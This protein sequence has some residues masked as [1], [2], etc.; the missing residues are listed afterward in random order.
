MLHC[1]VCSYQRYNNLGLDELRTQLGQ[2]FDRYRI[3]S[4][5]QSG[6]STSQP[7]FHSFQSAIPLDSIMI[8]YDFLT[9]RHQNDLFHRIW[10]RTSITASKV[11]SELTIQD[12]VTKIWEPAFEE[13]CRILESLKGRTMKLREIDDR[14]KRYDGPGKIRGHLENLY[15]GVELCF[16]R[17]QS[18]AACPGWIK[19]AVESM[20]QY[21]TLSRYAK[22]AQTILELRRRL[23]L[24]G[25]FSIME[26]I[27][28]QVRKIRFTCMIILIILIQWM[29]S[30]NRFTCN[31]LPLIRRCLQP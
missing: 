14:F 24:T 2:N 26:T 27:A 22:A 23:E 15:K 18:S 3:R 1:T 20:Q 10:E 29:L 6:G 25:E 30:N 16:G 31:F 19:S 8:K 5:C 13:C 9:G 28:T 21:W 12:I 7:I 17:G 11:N 4:L